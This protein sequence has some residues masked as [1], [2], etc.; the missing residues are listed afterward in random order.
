MAVLTGKLIIDVYGFNDGEVQ[1]IQVSEKASL[2]SAKFDV[3]ALNQ[4]IIDNVVDY[5]DLT[6]RLQLVEGTLLNLKKEIN[7]ATFDNSN[8]SELLRPDLYL[9]LLNDIK[10]VDGY[11][12]KTYKLFRK[13]IKGEE[14]LVAELNID[15]EFRSITTEEISKKPPGELLWESNTDY[16]KAG[17]SPDISDKNGKTL[18]T[19]YNELYEYKTFWLKPDNDVV[20]Q[21]HNTLD[22]LEATDRIYRFTTEPPTYLLGR[23][24]GYKIV[25][26]GLAAYNF[27]VSTDAQPNTYY[28]TKFEV[29]GTQKW[30][31]S[32]WEPAISRQTKLTNDETAIY[33]QP[34]DYLIP[35]SEWVR[36]RV[37]LNG[38]KYYR[39][40][41]TSFKYVNQVKKTCPEDPREWIEQVEGS[42]SSIGFRFNPNVSPCTY[43]PTGDYFEIDV[44]RKR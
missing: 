27:Y 35:F 41:E 6:Y 32:D 2:L 21:E 11:S 10:D 34:V 29:V 26:D 23:A 4:W 33:V 38:V 40:V 9:I 39:D 12:V 14:T 18:E 1:T 42:A 17:E 3:A 20:G 19:F 44:I 5:A 43:D 8:I 7:V 16:V 28:N 13:D 25:M 22:I 36:V 15:F 24:S 31:E 30:V 37:N